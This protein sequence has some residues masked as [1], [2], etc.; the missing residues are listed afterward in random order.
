MGN[1]PTA[2]FVCFKTGYTCQKGC[3]FVAKT[4]T[5]L[6]KHMREAH[7][8][9]ADHLAGDVHLSLWQLVLL[10]ACFRVEGAVCEVLLALS[11]AHQVS[12]SCHCRVHV[13]A[14]KALGGRC[15]L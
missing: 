5:E 14:S 13:A 7:K 15:V 2:L 9:K 6:L 1:A 3:S 11:A 8:G 10:Y 4:W 12:Q